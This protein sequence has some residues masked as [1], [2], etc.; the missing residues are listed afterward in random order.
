MISNIRLSRIGHPRAT[1]WAMVLLAVVLLGLG[2]WADTYLPQMSTTNPDVINS[3]S[4]NSIASSK[5][6]W[7]GPSQLGL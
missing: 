4:D 5:K 7:R 2:L 6:T 3:E 1:F